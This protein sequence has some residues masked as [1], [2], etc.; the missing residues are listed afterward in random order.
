MLCKAV[1]VNGSGKCRDHDETV[2]GEKQW[3]NNFQTVSQE[4][5]IV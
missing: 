2:I 3:L 1:N 4:N 5:I